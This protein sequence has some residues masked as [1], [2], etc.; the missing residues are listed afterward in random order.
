M[1][2]EAGKPLVIEEV[3]VAPPQANEVRLKILFTS[4]CHTDVYFWEAKVIVLHNVVAHTINFVPHAVI[5]TKAVKLVN[6]QGQTPLF[7][8]IFGHEAG[9]C[10][11]F[12]YPKKL[13][14][15]FLWNLFSLKIK[16]TFFNS[17]LNLISELWKVLVRV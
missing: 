5:H 11:P 15:F 14:C 2:W 8:R 1:A 4:L 10:A 7:P 13:N 12:P 3:E 17:V 16:L 6:F 9:G